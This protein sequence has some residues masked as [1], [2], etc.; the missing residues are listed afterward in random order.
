MREVDPASQPEFGRKH[1]CSLVAELLGADIRRVGNDS[2]E[3][4]RH[5]PLTN[6]EK[7][8][9]MPLDSDPEVVGAFSGH[10]DGF[11]IEVVTD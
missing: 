5:Q 2:V 4:R 11:C 10:P 9:L 8:P 6:L 7:I 1:L 3:F